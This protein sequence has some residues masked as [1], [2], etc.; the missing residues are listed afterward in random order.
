[1]VYGKFNFGCASVTKLAAV[2]LLLGYNFWEC[3]DYHLGIFLRASAPTGTKGSCCDVIDL[4]S[5]I[6]GQ[7]H[8]GLGVGLTGHAELYNC[9]DEHFFNVYFEGYVEHLFSR[10]QARSFDFTGKGCLSR[11]MLLKSFTGTPAGLV[12]TAP[13]INAINYATRTINTKVDVAGEGIVEFVYSNDCGFSAGIGYNIY[14]NSHETGCNIGA[15]CNAAANAYTLGFKGCTSVEDLCVQVT[16]NT[17]ATTFQVGPVNPGATTF[18]VTPNLLASTQSNATINGCSSAVVD[19]ATT[20]T[21]ALPLTGA[22]GTVCLDACPLGN[23]ESTAAI[24]PGAAVTAFL[25]AGTPP[26]VTIGGTVYN[27]AVNSVVGG[28]ATPVTFAGSSVAGLNVNSGLAGSQITNKV[29]GHLDYEWTD[30]DWTPRAYVGASGEFAGSNRCSGM[31]AWDVY[32]GVGV[33][34]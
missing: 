29:F 6:V 21:A 14:G 3:P 34:F 30:C 16:A 26:T 15:A 9:D 31:S 4:F 19:N 8:W 20:V 11:Y 7:N 28:V 22:T 18:T 33:S 5:P 10:C 17:G 27:L 12:T 13:L 1:M 24:I 32:V 25:P 2:N 23:T